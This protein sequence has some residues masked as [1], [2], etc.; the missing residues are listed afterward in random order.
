M[1]W[2][3]FFQ[4]APLDIS[5]RAIYDKCIIRDRN[6][7]FM[8]EEPVRQKLDLICKA[9]IFSQVDEIMVEQIVSD[10]RCQ[11]QRFPKGEI[12]YNETQFQRCLGII[13]AGRV[14]VEK[15]IQ[16]EKHMK[17]SILRPGECF[18]AAAMFQERGRY[19]TVLTA[20][21]TVEVLFLPEEVIR[22]AMRRNFT[23]T[24]NYIRYLSNR[25]WFLNEKITELTA[26]T[27]NQR[28]AGFL[29]EHCDADGCFRSS[30]TELSRQLNMGRATLYRALDMLEERGLINRGSK[31]LHIL[32]M[33]GLRQAAKSR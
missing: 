10:Q 31:V 9:W 18:G 30:M 11:Y 21:C 17:M 6:G 25:I 16:G 26:G 27:A 7:G 20:E 8:I 12:I 24:E 29:A 1:E 32:D 15:R 14:R 13:L 5:A 28:L 2:N 23:V 19:A 4:K 33:E 22:W 3:L